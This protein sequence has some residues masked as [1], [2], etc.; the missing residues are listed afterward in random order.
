QQQQQQQQQHVSGECASPGDPSC[1]E[2]RAVPSALPRSAP[3]YSRDGRQGRLGR[4][5]TLEC[6]RQ[7]RAQRDSRRGRLQ[8]PCRGRRSPAAA[9]LSAS[10][11]SACLVVAKKE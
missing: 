8:P 2:R 6:G 4:G 9:C 10:R 3:A 1:G 11:C 7:D 5:N